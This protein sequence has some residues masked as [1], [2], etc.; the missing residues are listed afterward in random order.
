[1]AAKKV[2]QDDEKAAPVSPEHEFSSYAAHPD[3][4]G[5]VVQ[6]LG[7]PVEAKD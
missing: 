7:V 6:T 4:P 2:Q 1:M 5:H 3:L